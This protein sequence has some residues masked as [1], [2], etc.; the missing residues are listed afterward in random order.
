MTRSRLVLIVWMLVHVW[1]TLGVIVWGGGVI[2]VLE[3]LTIHMPLL[4][5]LV[6]CIIFVPCNYIVMSIFV[7]DAVQR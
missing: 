7:N 1:V 4:G 6:P 5:V 2:A 3:R